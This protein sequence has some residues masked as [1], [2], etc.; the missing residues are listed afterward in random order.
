MH[1]DTWT[2]RLPVRRVAGGHMAGTP[3]RP[4]FSVGRTHDRWSERRA[5]G[6]LRVIG[7]LRRPILLA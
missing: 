6:V 1:V 3:A 4:T 7:G 5:I 2:A